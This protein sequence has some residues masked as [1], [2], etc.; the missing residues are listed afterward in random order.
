MRAEMKRSFWHEPSFADVTL[1]LVAGGLS[2]RMGRDK[3]W[4]PLGGTG[5]LERTLLKAQAEHFRAIILCVE[6]ARLELKALV[7]DTELP[8]AWTAANARAP[9][10]GLPQGLPT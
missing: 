10:R 7:K 8:C 6:D 3:R 4:L 1:L 2:S 9:W 5:L